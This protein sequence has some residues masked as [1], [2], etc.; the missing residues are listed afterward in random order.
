MVIYELDLSFITF[1]LTLKRA[2]KI[3]LSVSYNN[4]LRGPNAP[5]RYIDAKFII[6]ISEAQTR[7]KDTSMPK[8]IIIKFDD[9]RAKKIHLY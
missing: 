5:K 8:V 3:H 9:K 7:Q 2:K 6:I 4:Y 1:N